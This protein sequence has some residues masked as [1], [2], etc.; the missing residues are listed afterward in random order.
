MKF[1]CWRFARYI[2]VAVSLL[3]AQ[4]Q[5]VV[6]G[7]FFAKVYLAPT[8]SSRFIGLAQ[9]GES[10]TVI[11]TRDSWLRIRFKNAV[12][13]IQQSQIQKP[14]TQ[15]ASNQNDAA[16]PSNRLS[17]T[18]NV[19]T[20]AATNADSPKLE[21]Y[22]L[23]SSAE[24]KPAN[25]NSTPKSSSSQSNKPSTITEKTESEKPQQKR[26]SK[27]KNW[28]NQQNF[29]STLSSNQKVEDLDVKYFQVT[30]GP[31]RILSFLNPNAP[32]LGM[33]KKGEVFPL[34]GEGDSW[35]KV[36]Y[37][38]TVG[39]IERRNGKLIDAPKSLFASDLL[40]FSIALFMVGLLLVILL[41]TLSI[42]RKKRN[43]KSIADSTLQKN[44]LIIA[45][46]NKSIQYTL[47]DT[48]TTL[49]RCF[50]EIGFNISVAK[51]AASIRSVLENKAIDILLVDWKFERNIV[52]SLERLFSTIPNANHIL[53]I[54][55]N[56]SDP[57]AMHP[58]KV[59]PNMVF[60][61]QS[62][63]DRDIFK[64]V[65]PLIISENS[66]KVQ[67]SSQTSALQGNIADG[68]LLEVLQFIEIGKKTGCLLIET[69]CPFGLIYFLNGRIIFAA[70][71]QE[72][73]GK[74]AIFKVLNLTEGNFRFILN[75]KPKSSNVNLSTLEILMEW[76]KAI[77]EANGH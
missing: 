38:D 1:S 34:I 21:S 39:W 72:I 61:G 40:F 17:D 47:T 75:R 64:L 4:E 42:I 41:A 59:L 68:N 31:A 50:A 55:Y 56:T 69:D 28:F 32:I 33:A 29:L 2:L 3:F 57:T 24:Q 73:T 15:A 8:T 9:K 26:V 37:T 11:E 76:T 44:V 62:F 58:G 30:F 22:D 65:T 54:V 70:T 5:Q 35:C 36:V 14:G 74:D 48:T 12:G 18:Q 67:K 6:I 27:P 10:Y 52:S 7:D 49:E 43:N 20:V 53:C 16:E 46:T 25:E 13:W 19:N 77:D 71:A 63:S 45:K 23:V 51:D 60:L 66:K